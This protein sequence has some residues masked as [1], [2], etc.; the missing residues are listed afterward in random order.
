MAE[1]IKKRFNLRSIFAPGF[2]K[3]K[4]FLNGVESGVVDSKIVE[5]YE[6]YIK[7]MGEGQYDKDDIIIG[8]GYIRDIQNVQERASGNDGERK[9][10]A[11]QIESI[12][13]ERE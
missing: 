12:E 10:Q 5:E 2:K 11:K 3:F 6:G 13:N 8:N 1:T 9:K 7:A 4:D